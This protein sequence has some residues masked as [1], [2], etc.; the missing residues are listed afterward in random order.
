MRRVAAV[1]LVLAV[2][3]VSP[4]TAL[5]ASCHG[6]PATLIGTDGPDLL[7]GTPGDDV[8]V[9]GGGR[10]VVRGGGGNDVVCGGGGD[11][12]LIGGPGD[13]LLDGGA[14]D[15]VL[16]GGDGNDVLI[17]L[18]GDD[19]LFGD[20]GADLLDGGPGGDAALGGPDPDTLLGGAGDDRLS[21]Q[22]GDDRI[23]GHD[24]NDRMLGGAGADFLAGAAGID[25]LGGGPGA[26]RLLQGEGGGTLVGGGGG[27]LL[28]GSPGPDTVVGG[29][30]DDRAFG[31]AGDDSLTGGRG[32][33]RLVGGRGID[34]VAGGPGIDDC[35]GEQVSECEP[36]GLGPGDA[37]PEVAHLQQ[38][39]A[40][41]RLFR[42][43]FDGRYG[44]ETASAVVAF[45]K[46]TRRPRTETWDAG[47]WERL[48]AFSPAIPKPRPGEPDRVEVDIGRQ[49][50][51]LIR[52]G[53]VTA[54]VPVSTGSG[55]TYISSWGTLARSY[56]PR[57][58][59]TLFRFRPGWTVTR[60]GA[61][62][63]T[64]NFTPSFALHGFGSVPPVP[65]SHGCVRVHLWD[66]D[67]LTERLFLGI[68]FHVW[69]F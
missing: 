64:W 10:D 62:Y 16:R 41:A 65:A 60:L 43:P 31:L 11:D 3:G 1:V 52:G 46:A 36:E 63:D 5:E 47:D 24:G 12:R 69:D 39:L 50:L 67:W 13:D 25:H 26:D 40:A 35:S 37:G 23:E 9:G 45:H 59:F 22:G 8:I 18:G 28:M 55:G 38:R 19:R 7:V 54:V 33:D 49:V 21:G 53:R 48:A 44:V 15:D 66:A 2:A 6:R 30:G 57:G 27:D 56:T 51:T 29:P 68:P 14:G 42:G 20:A 4:A 58:D 61:I 32:A 17:G 34:S